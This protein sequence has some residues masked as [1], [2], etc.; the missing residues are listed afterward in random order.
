MCACVSACGCVCARARTRLIRRQT[1]AC[2][3]HILIISPEFTFRASLVHNIIMSV[4]RTEAKFTA[5]FQTELST[6]HVVLIPE[7]SV[8]SFRRK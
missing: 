3:S 6:N 8:T 4:K 7:V 5:R 2:L 1:R